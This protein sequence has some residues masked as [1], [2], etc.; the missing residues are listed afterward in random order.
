MDTQFANFTPSRAKLSNREDVAAAPDD[1]PIDLDAMITDVSPESDTE[2][3]DASGRPRKVQRLQAPEEGSYVCEECGKVFNRPSDLK[4]H[5][6]YHLPESERPFGCNEC[7]RRFVLSKDLERHRA[8]QHGI[9]AGGWECNVCAMRFTRKDAL[10]RHLQKDCRPAENRGSQHNGYTDTKTT[11]THY[12]NRSVNE[13]QRGS[14]LALAPQTASVSSITSSHQQSSTSTLSYRPPSPPTST[15]ALSAVQNHSSTR[16]RSSTQP[17][18]ARYSIIHEEAPQRFE[19][20]P[21]SSPRSMRLLCVLPGTWE[22]ILICTFDEIA[23]GGQRGHKPE[24]P[25]YEAVSWHWGER[26]CEDLTIQVDGERGYASLRVRSRLISILKGLRLAAATRR[27]WIDQACICREYPDEIAFQI[28]S[29]PEIFG[30]ARSVCVW[31]GETHP[32]SDM[33]FSFIR[34]AASGLDLL[35]DG[36]TGALASPYFAAFVELMRCEWFSRLWMVSEIAFAQSA[37]LH[38]GSNQIDWADLE[39][40][41]SLFEQDP[42]RLLKLS[43]KED[44]IPATETIP[45]VR[46]VQAI[47][48]LF[49]KDDENRIIERK[50]SLKALVVGL[51]SFAINLSHD[52][53]YAVLPLAKD[54]TQTLRSL[55]T[56]R[57][58]QV[59]SAAFARWKTSTNISSSRKRAKNSVRIAALP[60]QSRVS[61]ADVF[62]IDYEQDPVKLFQ[63][64]IDFTI[65]S[66]LHWN[67]LDILCQPWAPIIENLPSWCTTSAHATFETRSDVNFPGGVHLVRTNHDSLTPCRSLAVYGTATY[68][69]CRFLR[70]TESRFGNEGDT[71]PKYTLFVTGFVI[72]RIQEIE[73]YSQFGS[74][75]A[76]WFDLADWK[77]WKRSEVNKRPPQPFWRTLVADRGPGG[78]EVKPY[79]PIAL[80]KITRFSSSSTGLDA[81]SLETPRRG[82]VHEFVQRM[83]SVIWNRKL[84]KSGRH[85]LLGLAPKRAKQGD[86]KSFFSGFKSYANRHHQLYAFLKAAACQSYFGPNQTSHSRSLG[87]AISIR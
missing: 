30:Q 12:S 17:F 38:C 72:D 73:V 84:F 3:T 60:Q 83:I 19:Y 81:S 59:A 41:V 63:Q 70:A 16:I 6:K 4:K 20:A 11:A 15:A 35:P 28:A 29:T 23:L 45:A 79:Y 82:V 26:T 80:E 42:Q 54:S 64:F 8:T 53:I 40:V 9:A 22:D 21:L 67:N 18:L 24:T 33:A 7:S 25:D 87:S 10:K 85:I 13:N 48:S 37:T 39:M 27:L 86:G 2:G 49:R 66:D 46:L 76:E 56:P 57:E 32:T 69:A 55:L 31:L 78:T 75:P 62:N 65:R 44:A 43:A 71:V 52:R 14:P 36:T 50:F 51:S 61:S 1:Q 34:Q 77:P 47:S 74:I 58:L 68:N 5:S